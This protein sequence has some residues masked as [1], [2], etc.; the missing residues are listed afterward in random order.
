[1]PDRTTIVMPLDLK[2]RAVQPARKQKISFGE[3]VR[4][5]VEQHLAAQAKRRGKQKTG[6]PFWDN[7]VAFDDKGPTDMSARIDY[8]LVKANA[9]E[10]RRQRRVSGVSSPKRRALQRSGSAVAKPQT[11]RANQQSRSR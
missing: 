6:D 10:L 7:W 11:A 9:D 1:V 8:Y 5:A 2:E 3:L 4:R